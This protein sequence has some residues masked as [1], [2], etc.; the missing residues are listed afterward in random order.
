MKFRAGGANIPAANA[1]MRD[2][3]VF[4]R[5]DKETSVFFCAAGP[6]PC[7]APAPLVLLRGCANRLTAFHFA[8]SGSPTVCLR[9]STS[10]RAL[11]AAALVL[12]RGFGN[13]RLSR[14]DAKA[15]PCFPSQLRKP[16][17][18]ALRASEPPA[19]SPCRPRNPSVS[20]ADG[21]PAWRFRLY[22]F[23]C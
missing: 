21:E 13:L 7:A 10:L 3:S 17:G 15:A 12:F 20:S 19:A 18:L 4:Q 8:C 14:A 11:Q 16:F 6:A 1:L 5:F 23:F 2:L 9:G 22:L